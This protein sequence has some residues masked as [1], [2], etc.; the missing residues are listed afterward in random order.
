ML[1]IL[2]VFFIGSNGHPLVCNFM[3]YSIFYMHTF[4]REFGGLG[5]K[6]SINAKAKARSCS[7]LFSN[8][9]FLFS[10]SFVLFLSFR[11]NKTK[12]FV[13]KNKSQSVVHCALFHIVHFHWVKVSY[14]TMKKD[15][16]DEH[17]SLAKNDH[18]LFHKKLHTFT[19][20]AIE[21]ETKG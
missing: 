12:K 10:P 17:S 13:F 20:Q 9:I 11:E 1:W 18:F 21:S 19:V 3:L 8:R 15:L 7:K 14:I 2:W 6:H 5:L 16:S 4:I